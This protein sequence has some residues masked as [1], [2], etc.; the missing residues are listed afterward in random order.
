MGPPTYLAFQESSI[1]GVRSEI[2]AW[3]HTQR[4]ETHL[5]PVLSHDLL[6]PAPAP[7]VRRAEGVTGEKHKI[8]LKNV[9]DQID[10][11]AETHTVFQ[12]GHPVIIVRIFIDG[13]AK[14]LDKLRLLFF[15]VH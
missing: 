15:N 4:L 14:Y 6:A 3:H 2:N 8:H 5:G 13:L 10:S 7:L 11:A 12:Q 1:A 9:H